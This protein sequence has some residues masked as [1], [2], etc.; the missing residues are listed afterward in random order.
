MVELGPPRS[1]VVV[2]GGIVGLSTAWFLQERD[3]EVTVVERG[4]VGEGSSWGNAG[5]LS[6]ALSIPIPEPSVLRYGITSLMD[7]S[8]PLSIPARPDPD[9][10]RFL[11]R[12]A[13]YCTKRAWRRGME[14][15]LPI[16]AIALSA[17]DDLLAGGVEASTHEA[18]ITACFADPDDARDLRHEFDLISGS[19][20]P[21]DVVERTGDEARE[22]LPQVSD[23]VVLALEIRGQRFIDPGAFVAAL[24]DAVRARGGRIVEGF[25]ARTMRHGPRGISVEAL[26][27]QPVAADAVV[28]ANGVWINDLARPLG[29]RLPVRAGRGYSVSVSTKEGVPAPIYFPAQ[30]VACTPYREGLRVAGTMEFERADAPLNPRRI[31]VVLDSVRHLLT[32]ADLD[33]PRDPWVGPRPVSVDGLPMIGASK[34]PGVYIAGGHGMWGITLGPATGKLLAEQ[35]TTG[36]APRALARFDPLR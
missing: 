15:Y 28:V 19:G 21:L 23:D 2:G 11:T 22:R 25:T 36:V 9:L 4:Y 35:M 27:G 1:A 32:G 30:K 5:W 6:P 33:H 13:R 17:Y 18:P 3:V 24:A 34:V 7:P 31:D 12:M 29:V 20:Q 10:W 8:S 26:A 16:N 14:G